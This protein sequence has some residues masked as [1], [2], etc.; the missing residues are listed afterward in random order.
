MALKNILLDISSVLGLDISDDSEKAYQI[1]KVNEAAHELY[2]GNDLPGCLRE[3]IFQVND[4]ETF[5]VSLPYYVDKIRAV[6]FYDNWIGPI[7]VE[8]M[9]PRYHTSKWGNK[10]LIRARVKGIGVALERDL[11]DISPL[12][13]MLADTAGES[14]AVTFNIVG[15]TE[16]AQRVH[17]ALTIPAGSYTATSVNN[18]K[19]V[20]KIEKTDYNDLDV[21]I[22]DLNGNQVS[23]I[24]NSELSARF[25]IIMIRDDDFSPLIN[26][27]YPLNTIEV[28]YK[29]RF[30]PFKEL[31]DE[32]PCPNCDKI[33]FWKF[34]EHYYLYKPGMEDKATM[35]EQKAQTLIRQLFENDS[36]GAELLVE[37]GPNGFIEAQE[38]P[39][40]F[41]YNYGAPV[42]F[43][44][45]TP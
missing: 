6:R 13:F 41:K 1:E 17:E 8:S 38:N 35:A 19:S 3:Q 36:L 10:G 24:P 20:E 23:S 42:P 21:V 7:P 32:F 5:Q 29:T 39:G 22:T 44:T 43:I 45:Y 12:I 34:L 26:N 40:I 33:I 4:S 27:S 37:F 14:E 31:Y 30:S 28:L 25:T 2:Y 15:Q 16:S 11:Q 9:T 18:Y